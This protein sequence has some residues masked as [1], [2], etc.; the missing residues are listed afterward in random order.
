MLY[1]IT[2]KDIATKDYPNS[3]T[4]SGSSYIAEETGISEIQSQLLFAL[5]RLGFSKNLFFYR[6][7]P[8]SFEV[9]LSSV[10]PHFV[11]MVMASLIE[12]H[13][14]FTYPEEKFKEI[15]K[16]WR[17]L[18]DKNSIEAIEFYCKN[19]Q[20]IKGVEECFLCG[21][22]DNFTL[23]TLVRTENIEDE[24]RV[25]DIEYD[26]LRKFGTLDIDFL[27]L[28]FEEV[29]RVELKQDVQIYRK[30]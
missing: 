16:D 13:V 25:Y 1:E 12:E 23:I 5:M 26:M 3:Q 2:S 24:K 14:D 30:L 21:K 28:P 29:V 27:V 7:L 17:S 20:D 18:L 4:L 10:Y 6:S 15:T 9:D 8:P 19:T 22:D 11:P